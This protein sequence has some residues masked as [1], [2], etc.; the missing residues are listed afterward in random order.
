LALYK[1]DACP[2]CARVQRALE[3]LAVEVER[4]DVRQNP[5][6]RKDLVS[7][8]GGTQVPCLLIDDY[9]LLESADI[10]AWLEAY[11]ARTK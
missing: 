8:A 3:R 5:E 9:P 4:R 6:W 11:A 10:V 2:Y 1:Y 7:R